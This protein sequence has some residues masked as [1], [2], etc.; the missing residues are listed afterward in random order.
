MKLN[1][2]YK[3]YIELGYNVKYGDTITIPIKHLS[4][5]SHIKI[6]TK[7]EI[8]GCEKNIRY[9]D[10]NKNLKTLDYYCCKKCSIEK[11]KIILQEKYG[12]DNI[13]K[14]KEIREKSKLTIM[15][16]YGVDNISKSIIIK[17]KK[18]E[19]CLKNYNVEYPSQSQQII[20]K[21]KTTNLEKYNVNH[22]SKTDEC[23]EKMKTTNLERYGVEHYTKTDECKEKMKTTNLERYGVEFY[24][25]CNTYK[26]IRCNKDK[27]QYDNYRLSVDRLSKKNIIIIFE[28]WDGYDYYD[29]EYI[30]ENFNLNPNHKNYPTIDHKISVHYGFINNISIEE[31]SKLSNLCVTKRTI[32][33]SKNKNNYYDNKI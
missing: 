33:S 29:N 17:N 16:K 14:L 10:Y 13:L 1:S 12:V 22:Y 11:Q 8:C 7:C 19:T 26:N 6:D 9:Q 23:K 4:K 25:M 3:Y 24:S 18:K 27:S 2:N 30:K 15:T 21:M 31:I 32:N 5:N 20:E 28:N